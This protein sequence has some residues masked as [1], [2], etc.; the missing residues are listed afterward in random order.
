MKFSQ[1]HQTH[2]R[3]LIILGAAVMHASVNCLADGD[4]PGYSPPPEHPLICSTTGDPPSCHY[5]GGTFQ[6]DFNFEN[7]QWIPEINGSVSTDIAT[8]PAGS[9]G[10]TSATGTA[11]N[12]GAALNT[13]TAT[14]AFS[15]QN[16]FRAVSSSQ[17]E[18]ASSKAATV[19]FFA[20][21]RGI[22][23]DSPQEFQEGQR[24]LAAAWEMREK[25]GQGGKQLAFQKE[26]LLS[27]EAGHL[28]AALYKK[29][30]IGAQDFL[31]AL[32]STSKPPW[33]KLLKEEVLAHLSKLE[34]AGSQ[35]GV[36]APQQKTVRS[37]NLRADL[38]KM[39]EQSPAAAGSPQTAS[40]VDKNS[41]IEISGLTPD[42]AFFADKENESREVSLFEVVHNKYRELLMRQRS[43]NRGLPRVGR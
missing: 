35:G 31:V 8:T 39:I 13:A 27:P 21:A 34:E 5:E 18:I 4:S 7:C 30:A 28:M 11:V 16:R 15:E 1:G 26:A 38:R 12:T 23:E 24:G 3:F 6:C 10:T 37:S 41:D 9:R 19:A 32:S 2:S 36:T 22:T 14:P 17:L 33:E 42:P 25:A 29:Q 43:A 20:V 40:S